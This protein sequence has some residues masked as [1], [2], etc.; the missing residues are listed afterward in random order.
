MIWKKVGQRARVQARQIMQML[1][2]NLRLG[3]LP[4]I[5]LLLVHP[6]CIAQVKPYRVLLII[7][8]QW[9][10]PRSFLVSGGGEFQT[11]VTL[12]KSWGIPFDILRLDQVAMD[13]NQF[14][15]FLGHPRYGAILW[16]APDEISS[17]DAALIT[18]S[19]EKLHISLIAIGDRI[20]QP[21]IQQLLGIRY[22]GEWMH[23]SHP[24]ADG[25]SFLLRGLPTDLRAEGPKVIAMQR[26][27]VDVTDAH[28]LAKA[29][30]MPQITERELANDTRAIWIGGDV[31]QML[32][33]QPMRTALRRSITEA[34]GY[35]LVKTWTN[36]I[37]LTMDD[38]GNAQNSCWNIGTIPP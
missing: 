23:S 20:Q 2:K 8:K 9:K 32:L 13:P 25:Q 10:D 31:D 14:T 22:K 1:C 34:I 12:F 7:S 24:M 26:V 30:D 36:D 11:M 38:L 28:A 4:A 17:S 3:F 15:D 35:A 37:V 27:Q 19:V 33:Y 16:D 6:C 18:D 21:A 5:L 29:G